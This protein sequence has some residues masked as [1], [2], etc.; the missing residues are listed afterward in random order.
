MTDHIYRLDSGLCGCTLLGHLEHTQV[1]RVFRE[2]V[3]NRFE[4][5]ENDEIA[6]R[7]WIFR[8]QD[9]VERGVY[10]LGYIKRVYF[11]VVDESKKGAEIDEDTLASFIGL[12]KIYLLVCPEREDHRIPNLVFHRD[13]A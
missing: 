11:V 8:C 3:I 4:G 6:P 12:D 9:N 7:G 5:A 1:G 10:I 13:E 2:I